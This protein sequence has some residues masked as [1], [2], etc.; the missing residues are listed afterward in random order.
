[1][2]QDSSADVR[3]EAAWAVGLHRCEEDIPVLKRLAVDPSAAVRT[4][5]AMALA[6]LMRRKELERWLKQEG[7]QL[8]FEVLRELD[9]ALYAPA[10]VR[11]S[12][13]RIGDDLV[14]MDLGMS[15]EWRQSAGGPLRRS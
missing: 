5:A 7:H 1:M 11:K 9:F 13:P 15:G 8:S 10:W 3:R 4:M 2:T 6:R 12:W 14:R